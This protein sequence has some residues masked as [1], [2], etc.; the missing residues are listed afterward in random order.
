MVPVIASETGEGTTDREMGLLILNLDGT[1]EGLYPVFGASK[2]GVFLEDARM[3]GLEAQ[4]E[5]IRRALDP[6]NYVEYRILEVD[7]T[8]Y[9]CDK[10]LPYPKESVKVRLHTGNAASASEFVLQLQA[11]DTLFPDGMARLDSQGR[12]YLPGWIAQRRFHNVQITG[13]ETALGLIDGYVVVRFT[14]DGQFDRVV[15]QLKMLVSG[16]HPWRL[17]DIDNAGNLYY[18]E[19]TSVGIEIRMVPPQ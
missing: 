19:F 6:K 8:E 5:W 9:R 16:S 17:W 15:A 12:I 10:A 18:L 1:W 3:R 13:Q 14:A 11:A 7:G 4:K 2:L